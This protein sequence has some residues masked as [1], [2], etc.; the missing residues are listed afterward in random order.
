MRVG[1]YKVRKYSIAWYTIRAYYK[2]RDI[3]EIVAIPLLLVAGIFF[4][5]IATSLVY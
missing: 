5:M 4:A 2:V 1:K 3:A